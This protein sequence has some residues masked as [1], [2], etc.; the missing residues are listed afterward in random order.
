MEG[1]NVMPTILV[2]DDVEASRY[3][4]QKILKREG[5]QVITAEDGA[6]TL[7]RAAQDQPDLILLDI[8]MPDMDGF[9]VCK[10][11]KRN[12]RT[13]VI[14]IVM[15]SATY[16]DP[17]SRIRGIGLG[18]IDYLTHPVH[19]GELLARVYSNLRSKYYYDRAM[20]DAKR[21]KLLAEIGNLLSGALTSGQFSREIPEKMMEMFEGLGTALLYRDRSEGRLR[22]ILTGGFLSGIERDPNANIQES[23][24]LLK[25]SL[26]TR[27]R[28]VASR[29][30]LLS[31]PA[32][33]RLFN[34]R[35]FDGLLL[36]PLTYKEYSKGLLLIA[37]RRGGLSPEE[38]HPLEILS[39]QLTAA[40]L[41]QEAYR[42]LQRMN[43][44]LS[45]SNLKLREET[46]KNK[47]AFSFASHDL[48]T[49]LNAVMGYASL[50]RKGTL[51]EEKKKLAI[52]RILSNS[53]DLLRMVEKALDQFRYTVR[54]TV[55][56]D[57]GQLIQDEIQNELMPLLFGKEVEVKSRIEPGVRLFISDPDLIKHLLSNLFSNAAKFTS[58]GT[59]KI[60]AKKAKDKDQDGIQIVISDT[61]IGIES[62]RLPHIFKPFYHRPGYEGSGLGLSIVLEIVRRIQ[63][64]IK[65]KSRP[66]VGTRF[67]LWLPKQC[68][69]LPPLDPDK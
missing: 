66:G 13:E 6:G 36:S 3:V 38:Q 44:T 35:T 16:Y 58:S 59:I 63:G 15:V 37:L 57:L 25:Q 48:K 27:R 5:F 10:R 60:T 45:R 69:P 50:F 54:E 14:P 52:E 29:A 41:N 68:D 33:G 47:T 31:D 55:E 32:L 21:F 8:N 19:K 1:G 40:L 23:E 12:P 53:K 22:W 11:L 61:G 43:E 42:Y 2:V 17:E 20:Q 62:D 18:A 4:M 7:A 67:S 64:K 49:P 34:G 30:D 26:A 24:G 28:I 39:S 9:E 65:L 56:V 51:D 46:I